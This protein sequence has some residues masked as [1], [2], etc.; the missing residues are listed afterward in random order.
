MTF[1]S[2]DNQSGLPTSGPGVPAGYQLA[3]HT[4]PEMN[5]L[6]LHAVY[7][8]RVDVFVAE[9]SCPAAEIDAVDPLGSTGHLLART[10][11]RGFGAPGEVVGTARL[12]PS[13]MAEFRAEFAEATGTTIENLRGTADDPTDGKEGFTWHIGRLVVHPDHRAGGLGSALFA[14]CIARA[15][16]TRRAPILITAQSHLKGYYGRFGF[17]VCGPEFDWDGVPH[18]PMRRP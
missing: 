6:D 11:A 9:Q 18:L 4:L 8:L 12:F 7:K 5:P 10:T 13:S 1:P 17:K 3:W 2:S 16:R 15:D 14:E